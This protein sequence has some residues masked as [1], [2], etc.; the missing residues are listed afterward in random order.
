MVFQHLQ[1]TAVDVLL[2]CCHQRPLLHCGVMGERLILE[3]HL[4]TGL[5]GRHEAGLTGD[6]GREENT[7]QTAGHY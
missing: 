3:G 2:D 7:G 4:Q 5:C 1:Q 6:G